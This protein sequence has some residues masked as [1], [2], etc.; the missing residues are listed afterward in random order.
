[1]ADFGFA[2][3]VLV[4]TL[5]GTVTADGYLYRLSGIE[6]VIG[7][8]GDVTGG[9]DVL[10][11]GILERFHLVIAPLGRVGQMPDDAPRGQRIQHPVGRIGA[12]VGIEQEIRHPDQPVERDP[13]Q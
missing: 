13:F 8:F 6:F 12:I 3:E 11:G 4:D 1:M 5:A 9:D 2:T 10:T 7:F